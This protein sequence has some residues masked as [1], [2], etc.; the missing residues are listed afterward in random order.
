MFKALSPNGM[1]NCEQHVTIKK[2]KNKHMK[3]IIKILLLSATFFFAYPSE[4]TAQKRR[5]AV[6]KHIKKHHKK[7]A[8]HIAHV[9][10]RHL[11][12]RGKLVRKLG[13]GFIGVRFKGVH[14]RFH[15][16]VCYRP[17]G[18]RFMVIRAPLGIRIRKL[19]LGYRRFLLGTRHY[20]Y[21]YGTYYVKADN[22]NEYIVVDAPLGAKIDALPEGYDT[23]EVNGITY[24]RL[25][26]VYYKFI[27]NSDK[28]THFI[29]T[30]AP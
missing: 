14:F 28:D 24:Y 9:R 18:N 21:Y 16:G 26:N 17:R 30:K 3:N 13:V 22:A 8:R 15:N 7:K 5:K 25:D 12:K 11:P 20:F 19:P 2:N 27:V 23:L 6:K 1:I 10:Y 4:I 29:V